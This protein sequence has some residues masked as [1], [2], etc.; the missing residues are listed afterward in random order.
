MSCIKFTFH[1]LFARGTDYELSRGHWDVQ[2]EVELIPTSRKSARCPNF[3]WPRRPYATIP[4]P[5]LFRCFRIDSCYLYSNH[6]VDRC[7]RRVG[8]VFRA[9]A[10]LHSHPIPPYLLQV[11]LYSASSLRFVLFSRVSRYSG[12]CRGQDRRLFMQEWYTMFPTCE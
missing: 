12:W 4:K 3:T 2:N 10:A 6:R 8:E 11:R 7:C 1:Y 9:Y 5:I